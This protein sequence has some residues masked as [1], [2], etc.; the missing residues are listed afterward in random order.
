[1]CNSIWCKPGIGV[2]W[3]GRI[4]WF[5][6]QLAG[7][8]DI[9]NRTHSQGHKIGWNDCCSW[10]SPNIDIPNRFSANWGRTCCCYRLDADTAALCDCLIN[11]LSATP[12]FSQTNWAE[13][14]QCGCEPNSI[15]AELAFVWNCGC[16]IDGLRCLRDLNSPR[17]RSG[18]W[19]NGCL[20]SCCHS[21]RGCG[22]N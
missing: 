11:Q 16:V 12:D 5:L 18:W 6:H 15:P 20:P 8:H 9:P 3:T 21:N 7:S 14:C 13:C 19:K 1:M 22:V 2:P 4:C 10:H 17:I